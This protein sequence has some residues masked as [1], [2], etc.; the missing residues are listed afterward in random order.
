MV[1]TYYAVCRLGVFRGGK[2]MKVHDPVI[3]LIALGREAEKKCVKHQSTHIS[4]AVVCNEDADVMG[5]EELH[6]GTPSFVLKLHRFF[7]C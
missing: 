4:S 2:P 6:K 1:T 7:G 3:L 5:A